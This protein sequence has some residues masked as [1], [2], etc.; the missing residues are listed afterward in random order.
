MTTTIS[1]IGAAAPVLHAV[2]AG[3]R[4]FSLPVE[5]GPLAPATARHAVRPALEAWGLDENR[6]YDTLLVISELVTNAVTHASPPVVL[7][8]HGSTDG[9]G[10]QIHV[11]DGGART[12]ADPGSWAADRSDDEHG[13]GDLIVSTL[14]D[15]T[16]TDH[17]DLAGL[18]DHWAD[19]ATA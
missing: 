12:G 10:I 6:I 13:R 4:V 11:T 18:I 8:L 7:H 19:L 16:G 3:E 5:H 2:L 14:T 17:D 9:L 15:H 1:R